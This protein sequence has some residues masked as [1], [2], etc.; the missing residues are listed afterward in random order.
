MPNPVVDSWDAFNRLAKETLQY[1]PLSRRE[2][3]DTFLQIETLIYGA[4]E[5]L[6]HTTTFVEDSLCYLMAEIASGVI[7]S[8]KIYPGKR[9][10]AGSWLTMNAP[11]R[12]E[13]RIVGF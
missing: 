12:W 3:R 7:K 11:S 8:R 1:D 2:L 4:I 9:V 5:Y 10:K 6:L 13:Q